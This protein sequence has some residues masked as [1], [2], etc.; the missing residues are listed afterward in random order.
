MKKHIH[1]KENYI[2]SFL[3]LQKSQ[4]LNIQ[5]LLDFL[6]VSKNDFLTKNDILSPVIPSP[7]S[8]T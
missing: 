6:H 4:L 2:V 7:C 1:F 3:R 8:S 5:I